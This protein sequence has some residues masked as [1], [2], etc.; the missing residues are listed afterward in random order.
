MKHNFKLICRRCKT[1]NRWTTHC[2]KCNT[3]KFDIKKDTN[4][5][6]DTLNKP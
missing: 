1:E 4:Y 2:I 5:A 6:I 3:D